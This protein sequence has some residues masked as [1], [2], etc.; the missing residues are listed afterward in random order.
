[1]PASVSGGVITCTGTS[2]P[3]D[4]IGLAGVTTANVGSGTTAKSFINLGGLHV[5][6]ANGCTFTHDAE[7]YEV[8]TSATVAGLTGSTV[9]IGVVKTTAGV[10]RYQTDPAWVLTM[11]GTNHYTGPSFDMS[12]CT[13]TMNGSEIVM[14]A[15]MDLR[16]TGKTIT[17]GIIRGTG[18][19]P[20][21]G[22]EPL[23]AIDSNIVINGVR[24]ISCCFWSPGGALSSNFSGLNPTAAKGILID[25]AGA[26]YPVV[27]DMSG[28]GAN[29]LQMLRG[30]R[31]TFT[32]ANAGAVQT[33]DFGSTAN[34]EP[35]DGTGRAAS[36][37]FVKELAITVKKNGSALS[38]AVVT[39]K[40]VNNANR[41]TPSG[42]SEDMTS[43]RFYIQTT[44]GTGIAP[45][46]SVLFAFAYPKI[47][48]SITDPARVKWDYRTKTNAAASPL[49]DVAIKEYTSLPN[50]FEQS[51]LGTGVANV[52]VAVL[53]DASVT[54]TKT[55]ALALTSIA[56]LDNLYDAQKAWGCTANST[57]L[58]Y[59]TNGT[60]PISASGSVLDLGSRNL[61]INATASTAFAVNTSTNV[62]TIKASTLAAGAKFSTIKTTGTITLQNG[63]VANTVLIDSTGTKSKLT[64][65]NIVS[66]MVV[67]VVNNS[68]GATVASGVASGT[69][70]TLDY[71]LA[72]G[73][74]SL[75]TGLY[76]GRA[77]G[78]SGGY[79]LYFTSVTLGQSLQ[80]VNALNTGNSFYGRSAGRADRANV[81]VAWSAGVPTIT[82][83]GN[84]D[85]I[86]VFDVAM[87]SWA[88]VAHIT[89]F[90][91]MTTDG[92]T[93]NFGSANFTGTG[94]L[95]GSKQFFTAGTVSIGYDLILNSLNTLNV[96]ANSFAKIIKTSDSSVLRSYSAVS[97]TAITLD[98]PT[99]TDYK[100]Y[101][102]TP[103]YNG[104]VSVLNSGTGQVL[105]L[106]P[107]VHGY[108]N[109]STDIAAITPL[110]S[111]VNTSN[112]LNVSFKTMTLSP[113]QVCAVIEYI[114]KQEAFGDVALANNSA[115]I[116]WVDSQYQ[117]SPTSTKVKF[118]RDS[119]LT[120]ANAVFMQ[121]YFNSGA[122]Y[123]DYNFTPKQSGNDLFVQSY[124]SATGTVTLSSAQEQAILAGVWAYATRTLTEGGS[125]GGVTLE[126]IEAS[127]VLAMKADLV[128]LAKESTVA[129][130]L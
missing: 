8:S 98:L 71:A 50:V 9:N 89:D 124:P 61:V 122:S 93:Y 129:T 79:D 86:S 116:L 120:T 113:A 48:Y 34:T 42:E 70:L 44:A 12:L 17:N 21:N 101:L 4:F 24:P 41:S 72:A 52:S 15:F 36:A 54:L 53:D 31:A 56:T 107:I 119:T 27:R 43:D 99:N 33:V 105:T 121:T 67:K 73:V 127:E 83:S 60:F 2:T 3:A 47:P 13:F 126:E 82:L 69:S 1:M 75:D 7:R 5:R 25:S 40:D 97:G 88:T 95:T 114:Q 55:A 58:Y 11:I 62:I 19:T 111:M 80:T 20:E 30:S 10:S 115:N 106:S 91:P 100:V 65:A 46:M 104:L 109:A 51:M 74:T 112:V 123:P 35:F 32:N 14:Q 128:P 37:R 90:Q 39:T 125:G 130:L 22:E 16:G 76:T 84:T 85:I 29:P 94:R 92:L 81:S 28:A 57:N 117:I 78:Q 103:G 108:Y 66:G 6:F 77:T 64:V 49:L 59:P 26:T 110:I 38:G 45:T 18:I 96:P 23:I 102:K 68:T 63:A 87:E 118:L